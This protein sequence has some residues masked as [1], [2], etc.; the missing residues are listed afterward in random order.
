MVGSHL[1]FNGIFLGEGLKC[2]HLLWLLIDIIF[3][4]TNTVYFYALSEKFRKATISFVVSVRVYVRMEQLVSHWT[5]FHEIW[6][7][8][9]FRKYVE[10]IEVLL[11]G[12]ENT[13][14]FA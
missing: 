3:A 2:N 14:Y 1:E 6:Y 11:K 5:D 10:K 13:E 12:E 8:N 9:I 4:N 7:L